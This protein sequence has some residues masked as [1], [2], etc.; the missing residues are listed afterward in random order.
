MLAR[1]APKA[2]PSSGSRGLPDHVHS[3][4][5]ASRP[6]TARSRSLPV[7]GAVGSLPFSRRYRPRWPT[8]DRAPRTSLRTLRVRG[9][10]DPNVVAVRRFVEHVEASTLRHDESAPVGG[11]VAAP[12]VDT[13][14]SAR[15]A[16]GGGQTFARC[17]SRVTSGLCA[18]AAASAVSARRSPGI[19]TASSSSTSVRVRRESARVTPLPT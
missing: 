13:L 17:A 5:H 18:I 16:W 8:L 4:A 15:G 19:V 12:G 10:R 1:G 7:A 14:P 11:A 3:K 6:S 2:K 9:K